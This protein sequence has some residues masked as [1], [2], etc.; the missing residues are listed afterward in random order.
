[1]RQDRYRVMHLGDDYT[2]EVQDEPGSWSTVGS[3]D[4]LEK[5]KN[6]LRELNGDSL[7]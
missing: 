2:I 5:A 7:C 1:M 6:M 3:F 4:T